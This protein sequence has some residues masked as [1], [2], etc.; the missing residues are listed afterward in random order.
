MIAG[1][2][3]GA[4]EVRGPEAISGYCHAAV[5]AASGRARPGSRGAAEGAIPVSVR[6]RVQRTTPHVPL[7]RPPP[8]LPALGQLWAVGGKDRLG[9][10]TGSVADGR[11]CC[12]PFQELLRFGRGSFP[13]LMES[14]GLEAPV[15]DAH[16]VLRL[17]LNLPEAL[18]TGQPCLP[19]R[20]PPPAWQSPGDSGLAPS[21][22]HQALWGWDPAPLGP[23][24]LVDHQGSTRGRQAQDTC[25]W[26]RLPTSLCTVPPAGHGSPL[27]LT[28]PVLPSRSHRLDLMVP[29]FKSG[30]WVLWGRSG[31]WR[32][33]GLLPPGVSPCRDFGSPGPPTQYPVGARAPASTL[34]GRGCPAS[35]R[36]ASIIIL[37]PTGPQH[38][39]VSQFHLPLACRAP[40]PSSPA[41]GALSGTLCGGGGMLSSCWT[42]QGQGMDHS[43]W[44]GGFR[45]RLPRVWTEPAEL[46]SEWCFRPCSAVLNIAAWE[47]SFRLQPP[48]VP[49]NRCQ[50]H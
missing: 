16:C 48:P 47:G 42:R 37:G 1:G 25:L 32:L 35:S 22:S 28:V 7:P 36:K 23:G 2:G 21:V 24:Q 10:L 34:A 17:K 19:E 31:H 43:A 8:K 50:L 46:R 44:P 11:A 39:S 15:G 45:T 5:R 27:P 49:G 26:D 33:L 41:P 29:R 40:S 4:G 14:F 18:P 3:A 38:P 20:E 12:G 9:Q 6:G 30:R 13:A